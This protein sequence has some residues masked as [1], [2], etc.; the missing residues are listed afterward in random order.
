MKIYFAGSIRGGRDDRALYLEIIN[1]LRQYGEVLTE[2]VGDQVLSDF[3]EDVLTDEGIYNR[4]MEWLTA[5]D[6]IVAEVTTTSLGVGYEIGRAEDLKKPVLCLYR[7]QTG[8][9][10]SAMLNGN[11]SL[12]IEHYQTFEEATQCIDKFITSL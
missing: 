4:D 9:R 8:K 12:K 7:P 1:Y 6:V 10:L 3:G 11:D 2:H 5:S